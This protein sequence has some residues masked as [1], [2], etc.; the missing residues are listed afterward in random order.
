MGQNCPKTGISPGNLFEENYISNSMVV[1]WVA[2]YCN[3]LFE[4]A[5]VSSNGEDTAKNRGIPWD[6]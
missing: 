1:N 4:E 2:Y 3:Q 6:F 5:D